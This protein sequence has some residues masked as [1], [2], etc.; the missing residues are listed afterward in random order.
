M[1]GKEKT[2][3]YYQEWATMDNTKLE[4]GQYA[5]LFIHS[6]AMINDCSSFST[7]YHYSQHPVMYLVR[8]EHKEGKLNEFATAAF[9]LL[10]MGKNADDIERLIQMVISGDD[11]MVPKK[12]RILRPL[13]EN[14]LWQKCVRKYYQLYTF[15]PS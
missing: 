12:K 10:Y 4:D 9:N 2:D 8:E 3:Y 6:D 13:P 11:T 5:S 14:P 15:C 7:E 1:W